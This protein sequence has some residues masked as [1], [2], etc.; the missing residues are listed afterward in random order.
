M[1]VPWAKLGREPVI[2]EFDRLYLLAGPPEDSPT[3]PP[4][5]I[6]TVEGYEST[7]DQM[8][9]EAKRKR[10]AEAELKWLEEQEARKAKAQA[11]S[12]SN[13]SSQ[14][15]PQQD[16]SIAKTLGSRLQTM[17][18]PILGNLQLKL[19]NVHIR[20]EEGGVG[21][22]N[23]E[24]E[25]DKGDP[26]P[27]TT[28]SVN[29]PSSATNTPQ[30]HT[31]QTSGPKPKG[32][33]SSKRAGGSKSQRR[34][35]CVLGLMLGEVTAHTVDAKG[36]RA[37]VV[38]NVLQ[39]LRKA[40]ELSKLC[41]YFDVGPEPPTSQPSLDPLQASKSNGAQGGEKEGGRV[42]VKG[43]G[44][45]SLVGAPMRPPR[46]GCSWSEVTP[47]EWDAMLLPAFHYEARGRGVVSSKIPSSSS[48]GGGGGQASSSSSSQEIY[49]HDF[50]LCPVSGGMKYT[51]RS[52]KF[53]AT[54]EDAK[55]EAKLS[56]REVQLRLR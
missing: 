34:Q 50:I 26:P 32:E 49:R 12:G 6:E 2:V 17:I 56:L 4:S 5:S 14:Q 7:M 40:V 31:S 54:D 30:P 25:D 13:K 21:M 47:G 55:Q 51:R 45:K 19:S 28:A 8:E 15:P 46:E 9:L 53:R 23:E 29:K 22:D 18:E 38:D 48:G 52:P 36:Q 43:G 3:S 1:Q 10:V 41:V 16:E 44:G 35:S 39:C 24:D 37:F 27:S 20:Y 11:S 42:R 33:G